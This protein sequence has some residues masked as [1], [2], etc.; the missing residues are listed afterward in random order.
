MVLENSESISV[1]SSTLDAQTLVTQILKISF[2]MLRKL[3]LPKEEEA[4]FLLEKPC[5][6]VVQCRADL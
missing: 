5:L 1:S 3:A 4:V 2:R 6:L